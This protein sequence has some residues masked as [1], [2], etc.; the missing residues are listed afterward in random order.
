MVVARH[1]VVQLGEPDAHARRGL[2]LEPPQRCRLAPEL[3]REPVRAGACQTTSSATAAE[4]A[5]K[6]PRSN[7]SM[8]ERA[9]AA[10]G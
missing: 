2:I 8:A 7:A 10:L 5:S 3:A 6:S 4:N 1:D 9:T